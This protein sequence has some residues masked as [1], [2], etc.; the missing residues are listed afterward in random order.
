[1][2]ASTGIPLGIDISKASFDV[3]IQ[4]RGKRPQRAKF[5]N[6]AAG[7]EQLSQWLQGHGVE[8]RIHACLEATNIYGHA[9]ACYLY[10]QGHEV[11]IVNPARIKGYRQ[12]Q[13]SRT[14]N[15][16]ADAELNRRFC[17][18]IKPSLWHPAPEE[19]AQLQ[20][21]S[22]RLE[23]IEQ[24]M[25]QEKNRRHLYDD[26]ELRREIDAHLEFLETQ[27]QAVKKRLHAHIQAHESLAEPQRLLESIPG[28]G[29]H[30]ATR[31]LGEIGSIA[32]F[33]SARQLA[34]FAGLTPQEFKS[35]SSVHGKTRLCKIGN[36]R[37]RK[38]LF[39]PALVMIRYCPE[40]QAF[41]QRLLDAG[42]CK[43]QVVGAVMHKLIR[44]IYGV[45]KSG[46]P[47]DS[48]KL[49]PQQA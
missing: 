18:A 26:A 8:G 35:G 4:G 40:I 13:L 31:I 37:L 34:A 48:Q 27:A 22:R 33:G 24:M 46:Q 2:S 38:A 3:S 47:F 12:T 23:A 49:L 17:Q 19:V 21:L 7:F 36:A 11:S 42:K 9:L 10:Q 43:M 32:V 15:D 20:T 41:R 29:A 45:L 25:T 28:I 5:D 39:F 6:T 44:V 30:T 16:S 1:M 14:K